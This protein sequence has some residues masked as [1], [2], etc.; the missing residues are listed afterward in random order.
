MRNV[1]VHDY[2]G[3]DLNAVWQVVAQDLPDLKA[4]LQALNE[5]LSRRP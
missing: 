3:I 4:K 1:L 2:F 5:E